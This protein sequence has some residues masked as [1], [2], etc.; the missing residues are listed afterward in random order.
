MPGTVFH[1][2][3]D[4][5]ILSL[6]DIQQGADMFKQM[7]VLDPDGSMDFSCISEEEGW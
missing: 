6:F 3:D 7:E 4:V 5:F 1:I 2:L